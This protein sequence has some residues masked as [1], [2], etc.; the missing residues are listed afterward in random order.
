MNR[1][2]SI[3]HTVTALLAGRCPQCGH[4]LD[5]HD[6]SSAECGGGAGQCRCR[7]LELAV[8]DEFDL[9]PLVRPAS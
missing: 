3:D 4:G 1:N 6:P 5:L 8:A 2:L 7:V 9:E